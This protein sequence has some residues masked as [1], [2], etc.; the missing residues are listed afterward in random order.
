MAS[1]DPTIDELA[2]PLSVAMALAAVAGFLDAHLYLHVDDVFVANQSGN[3]ILLGMGVGLVDR[4]QVVGPAVSIIMFMVGMSV[5]TTVHDRRMAD[6]RRRRPDVMLGI[7]AALIAALGAFLWIAGDETGRTVG[8]TTHAALAIGALAMGLQTAVLKK[9]GDV[10]V[11][12][13]Y[14]SGAV[15]RLGAQSALEPT[16]PDPADRRHR[17]S[18]ITVLSAVVGAYAG[19]AAIS[20]AM[21]AEP[22]VLAIPF[23]VLVGLAVHVRFHIVRHHPSGRVPASRPIPAGGP[24]AGTGRNADADSITDA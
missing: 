11:A 4:S 3:V 6:G 13:T 18:V 10:A 1:P 15:A 22:W 8:A 24:S 20:A 19:G 5:A 2:G 7:E 12:T 23:V 14:A 9:V 17:R 21:S 16:T